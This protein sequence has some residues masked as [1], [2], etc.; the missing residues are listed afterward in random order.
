MMERR[1]HHSLYEVLW[2]DRYT[3]AAELLQIGID[4]LRHA[5][6]T[7]EPTAQIIEHDIISLQRADI[8]AWLDASDV[9]ECAERLPIDS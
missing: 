9:R 2:Q 4:V 1:L 5:S 3:P 6:F 8:L 7:G